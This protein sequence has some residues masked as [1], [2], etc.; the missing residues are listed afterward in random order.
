[1]QI[2]FN[3]FTIIENWKCFNKKISNKRKKKNGKIEER[4][5]EGG[6]GIIKGRVCACDFLQLCLAV[7]VTSFTKQSI[8]EWIIYNLTT[9]SYSSKNNQKQHQHQHIPIHISTQLKN[10]IPRRKKKDSCLANPILVFISRNVTV[11]VWNN[12]HT[13]YMYFFFFCKGKSINQLKKYSLKLVE[14]NKMSEAWKE[15]FKL[16]GLKNYF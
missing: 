8:Y 2:D 4:E 13:K 16:V 1:M 6:K 15:N 12:F 7:H 5:R 14:S 11:Y 9:Y 3:L 10:T